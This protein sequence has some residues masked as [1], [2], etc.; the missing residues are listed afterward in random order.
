MISKKGMQFPIN[1]K[2]KRRRPESMNRVLLILVLLAMVLSGASCFRSNTT[3]V[4]GKVTFEGKPVAGAEVRFG[5]KTEESTARTDY[6]GR[7]ELKAAHGPAEML[8]LKVLWPGYTHDEIK[9]P[10]HKSEDRPIDIELRKVHAPIAPT[11]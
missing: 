8:E 4:R 2:P 1:G 9:F 3:K 5:G 11:R 10:G 6:D 7:Y